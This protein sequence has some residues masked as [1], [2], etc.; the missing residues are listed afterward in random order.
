VFCCV[1]QRRYAESIAYVNK[2]AGTSATR[3]QLRTARADEGGVPLLKKGD[4]ICL[5]PD[6]EYL[7]RGGILGSR[8]AVWLAQVAEDEDAELGTFLTSLGMNV[9]MPSKEYR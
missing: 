5:L 1:F 3:D 6:D 7:E 2:I 4:V 8:C 9:H